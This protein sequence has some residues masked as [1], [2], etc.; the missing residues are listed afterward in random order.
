MQSTGRQPHIRV[1]VVDPDPD[2]RA[3]YRGLFHA[4]GWDVVEAVDGRDALVK[5]L[6][7]PPTLLVT[8]VRLP[9]LDGY[10]LCDILRRN[11]ATATVPILVVTAE[12]RSASLEDA[13][14]A[15]ANAVLIKPA[16][17]EQV[18]AETRRLLSSRR[19]SGRW[20]PPAAL[21]VE[22]ARPR[23]SK[24][25]ARFTTATPPIAP[26]RLV[27]PSCDEPLTYEHSYVGGVNA[28]DAEQSDF[29]VC[30]RSCGTFQ[31]RHRT[32]KLARTG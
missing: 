7:R 14:R 25:F 4:Y 2:T 18:L 30:P 6:A 13:R 28:Q 16:T 31:Y 15:G 5:A 17:S 12:A 9:F 22:S 24:A 10:T 8:E 3:L 29:Y 26:P 20:I 23:L 1:V 19:K 21:R 27:C 32:R 11:R